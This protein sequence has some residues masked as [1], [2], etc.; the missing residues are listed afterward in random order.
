MKLTEMA[1]N[2]ILKK[3]VLYEGEEVELEFD[4]PMSALTNVKSDDTTNSISIKF[5]AK[6]MSLRIEKTES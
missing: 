4:I 6:S 5:K 2:A 1:I 3:G